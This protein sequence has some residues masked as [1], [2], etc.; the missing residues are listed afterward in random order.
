M[1]LIYCDVP[2]RNE[3]LSLLPQILLFTEYKWY[4]I[5][6]LLNNGYKMTFLSVKIESIWLQTHALIRTGFP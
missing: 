1:K 4:L 6:R 5:V 3:D 2:R